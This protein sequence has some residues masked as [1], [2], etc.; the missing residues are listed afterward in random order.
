VTNDPDLS[1][2]MGCATIAGSSSALLQVQ[3]ECSGT[4]TDSG[5][6]IVRVRRAAPAD[7]SVRY[8]ST[9]GAE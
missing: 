1:G 3:F 9:V 7:A 5:S 6:L 8:R 2:G 4:S